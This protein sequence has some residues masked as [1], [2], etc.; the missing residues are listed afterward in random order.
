MTIVGVVVNVVCHQDLTLKVSGQYLIFWL[1]YKGFLIKWLTCQ[2]RDERESR[3]IIMVALPEAEVGQ[4]AG[5]GQGLPNF[6]FIDYD[7]C[8]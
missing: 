2:S 6:Q 8:I 7:I 3:V 1:S 4:E 5:L